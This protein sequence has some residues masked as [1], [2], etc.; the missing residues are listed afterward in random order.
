V[1]EADVHAHRLILEGNSSEAE[2]L[3]E[4]DD[5]KFVLKDP[6]GQIVFEAEATYAHRLVELFELYAEGKISFATQHGSLVFKKNPAAVADLLEFVE[7]GLKSDAQY[8]TRLRHQSMR[9]IVRGLA[10][11]V[12]AGG[13]F[14]LYCWYASWAPDPP[15]DHWVRWFGWLIHAILL[16]LLAV[17]LAGPL[18]AYFGF[19]QWLRFRRIERVAAM[20]GSD[21]LE[22]GAR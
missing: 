18:I 5:A 22:P 19:R 20:D 8:R 1:A 10:M 3:L 12:V 11:F 4:W 17:A 2:W 16:V 21:K 7:A 15:P 6:D 14:G 9:A 13:L